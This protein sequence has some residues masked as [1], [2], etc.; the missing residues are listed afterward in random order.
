[1][2]PAMMKA[3]TCWTM[4]QREF[5]LLALESQPSGRADS[6]APAGLH[7]NADLDPLSLL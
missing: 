2:R 3:K 7:L 4:R 5:C 1:M 6:A